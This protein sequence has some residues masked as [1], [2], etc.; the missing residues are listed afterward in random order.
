MLVRAQLRSC[1][2]TLGSSSTFSLALSVNHTWEG[3]KVFS[4]QIKKIGFDVG[5]KEKTLIK[6]KFFVILS[7]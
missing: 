4:Q 1:K 6:F 7:D 2:D 5:D 3:K